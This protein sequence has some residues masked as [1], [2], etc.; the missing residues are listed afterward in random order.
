MYISHSIE[1]CFWPVIGSEYS[2][3][4]IEIIV[5]SDTTSKRHEPVTVRR[6]FFHFIVTLIRDIEIIIR[7]DRDSIAISID[8]ST[9]AIEFIVPYSS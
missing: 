8:T 3:G 4:T 9:C 5:P 2:T 1:S 7:V 6:V